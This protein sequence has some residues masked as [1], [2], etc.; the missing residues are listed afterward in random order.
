MRAK[1]DGNGKFRVTLIDITAEIR[2]SEIPAAWG[3]LYVLCDAI[4][5]YYLIHRIIR[6]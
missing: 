6:Y 2:E 4:V 5:I 1:R 3:G